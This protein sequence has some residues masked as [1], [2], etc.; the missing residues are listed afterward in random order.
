MRLEKILNPLKPIVKIAFGFRETT[1]ILGII[2][3]GA[4]MSFLSPYFLTYENV[5]TTV[6][7][8]SINGIV[9]I[10]MTI[11]LIGGG[12]DLSVGAVMAFSGA[13]VGRLF[14]KGINIW[15][16][17]IIALGVTIIIG[18]FNGFFIT[19]VKLSPLITTLATMGIARGGALVVTK[20]MPLSLYRAPASFRSIGVGAIG[21]VPYLIIFLVIF[22]ALL[23]Y[24]VRKTTIMR[25]VFYVGSNEQAALF[26]GLNVKRIKTGTYVVS[27]FLAGIGG[28]LSISRFASASPTLSTGFEMDAIAACVIGGASLEGGEGTVLGSILGIGLLAIITSSM[29][30]LD[31]SVYWRQL[32]SSMILLFAVSLDILAKSKNHK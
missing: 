27:S 6:L 15:L 11:V 22:G 31:V 2:I 24:L 19:R 21:R 23:D 30:L 16:A 25:K 18:L 26:S 14:Q 1:L 17:L 7:S 4:V 12:I 10:G 8:F 29:V 9:V 5:I 28:M 13:I 20:G 32:V 3:I